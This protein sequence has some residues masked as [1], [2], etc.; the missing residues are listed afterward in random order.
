MT[1][2]SL[3]GTNGFSRPKLPAW[4]YKLRNRIWEF[5]EDL[6]EGPYLALDGIPR[7]VQAD[8]VNSTL[9][10]LD[11]HV[12]YSASYQVPVMFFQA[13][14]SDGAPLRSN[15]FPSWPHQPEQ[16]A[17]FITQQEHPLLP[18]PC[19][20]ALHP[21]NTA[22]VLALALGLQADRAQRLASGAGQEQEPGAP[23][24][25]LRR[26]GVR[27]AVPAMYSTCA[28]IIRLVAATTPLTGAAAVGVDA[29]GAD[30][31]GIE[32]AGSTPPGEAAVAQRLQ[33]EG[34]AALALLRALYDAGASRDTNVLLMA[35]RAGHVEVVRDVLGSGV[36]GLRLDVALQQALEHGSHYERTWELVQML[37]DSGAATPPAYAL[38]EALG[39][40]RNGGLVGRL[41]TEL[42]VR[43]D[44][45]INF[46]LANAIVTGNQRPLRARGNCMADAAVELVRAGADAD[47]QEALTLAC[48]KGLTPVALMLLAD[49]RYHTE[50]VLERGMV[51]A[52]RKGDFGIVR[53]LLDAGADA[54]AGL[55]SAVE[56]NQLEVVRALLT[57]GRCPPDRPEVREAFKLACRAG[58]LDAVRVLLDAGA[59]ASDGLQAAAA[60]GHAAVV[61]ALLATGRILPEHEAMQRALMSACRSEHLP[62]VRALLDA[63]ADPRAALRLVTVR[64]NQPLKDLLQDAAVEWE[65]AE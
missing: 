4:I 57:R 64:G 15:L 45:G 16:L 41:L 31:A 10:F 8:S 21:C 48:C 17:G 60:G 23:Q 37:R 22:V 40:N 65:D 62:V 47:P 1:K 43:R 38:C 5:I 13:A 19:W 28:P 18:G 59:D 34:E 12:C 9:A 42:G 11:Y 32:T 61:W 49:A 6:F 7:K 25:L 33:R 27:G 35:G 36:Q 24:H 3:E 53:E 14:S 58:A 30:S 50:A 51:A 63:G 29:S 52:C 54:A 39:R 46:F 56:R 44:R 20:Y 26:Y 2:S 55:G